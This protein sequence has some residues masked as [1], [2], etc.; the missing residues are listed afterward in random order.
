MNMRW[1]EPHWWAVGISIS[2]TLKGDSADRCWAAQLWLPQVTLTHS[3][4][5]YGAAVRPNTCLYS[6]GEHVLGTIPSALAP[7]SSL[8]VP[9]KKLP[10]GQGLQ[11]NDLTLGTENSIWSYL[12]VIKSHKV[13][14]CW[15]KRQM[16]SLR[17][18]HM[19]QLSQGEEGGCPQS[20]VVCNYLYWGNYFKIE[21]NCST[22]IYI[23]HLHNP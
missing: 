1:K 3:S 17:L 18:I 8:S 2:P 13:E 6:L 9:C 15:D 16:W 10:W 7:Q 14:V 20:V 4:S 22:Y 11:E 19:Q 12:C 23:L 5:A 21:I